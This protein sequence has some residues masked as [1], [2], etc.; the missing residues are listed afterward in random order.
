VSV[1]MS[2]K[3]VV[4]ISI[5]R[6]VLFESIGVSAHWHRWH[7]LLWLMLILLLARSYCDRLSRLSICSFLEPASKSWQV[8]ASLKYVLFCLLSCPI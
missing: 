8:L 3:E 1:S 7:G 2:V 5:D 6:A 4:S